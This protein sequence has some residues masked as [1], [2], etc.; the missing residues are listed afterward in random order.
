MT[1]NPLELSLFSRGNL[2]T[3][4]TGSRV[5]M[6]ALTR[7]R[8]G[9]DG[10][11]TDVNAKYYA[12][13][14][15]AAMIISEATAISAQGLGWVDT[16]GIFTDEQIEGWQKVTD[17][18]HRR[19]GKIFIQLW[20]MGREVH[21]DFI[22]GQAPVAPS[23][24][25]AEGEVHTY[26][27]KK[28]YAVPRA[29]SHD[30]IQGIISDYKQAAKNALK[31]GFDG[32]ELHAAGP[33]LPAQFLHDSSNHR[34]DAY[35]G[36]V[37][38]RARF[39]FEVVSALCEV[40]GS[41]RIGIKLSPEISLADSNTQATY[42]YVVNQLNRYNLAYLQMMERAWDRDEQPAIDHIQ[43]RNTYKGR[44]VANGMYD[45][46]S[47]NKAIANGSADYI[48]FGRLFISNPDLVERLANNGPYNEED[49]SSFFTG[50]ERGYVDYPSLAVNIV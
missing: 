25:A 46:D 1:K 50:D 34:T 13:R 37:E 19:G 21:P 24:I 10:V 6:A 23:P 48:S 31:A 42:L 33:Y 30:E 29:L 41:N 26:A 14:A 40:W 44:Y 28:P 11:P 2:G 45:L 16:P 49:M 4:E 17:E 43:L 3:L 47:A 22:G 8:V 20:H 9:R 36:S 18:V 38:N 12:Q 5:I 39:I 32:V 35:G 15:S 27:G 7:A